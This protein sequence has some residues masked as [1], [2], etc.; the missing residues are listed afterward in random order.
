M[1]SDK[2]IS[3]FLYYLFFLEV[4]ISLG[5]QTHKIVQAYSEGPPTSVCS[6]MKPSA[7]FHGSAQTSPIPYQV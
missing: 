2:T 5:P 4:E 1:T 6:S 3:I 7:N